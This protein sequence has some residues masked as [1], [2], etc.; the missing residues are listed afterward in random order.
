MSAT[1]ALRES[2][3]CK[4]AV[5]SGSPRGFWAK[6]IAR[7]IADLDAE[8]AVLRATSQWLSAPDSSAHLELAERAWEELNVVDMPGLE[9]PGGIA[10]ARW[11]FRAGY[12]AACGLVWP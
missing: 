5:A 8:R 7:R 3:R 2:A 11:G 6:R 4:R 10:N 12:L 9:E 1:E